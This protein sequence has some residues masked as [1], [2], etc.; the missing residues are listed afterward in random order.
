VHDATMV[1]VP[2]T[3]ARWGEAIWSGE[4]KETA[5]SELETMTSRDGTTIA[6]AKR[7]Q[8]P[9]VILGLPLFGAVLFIEATAR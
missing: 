5:M 4:S 6:F 8:G 3:N 2:N 9:A 7:G 1:A